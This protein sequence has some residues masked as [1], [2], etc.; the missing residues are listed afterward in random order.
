LSSL[1]SNLHY[2]LLLFHVDPP[3]FSSTG[4]EREW[5]WGIINECWW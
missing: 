2:F 3:S 1:S 4:K 5:K